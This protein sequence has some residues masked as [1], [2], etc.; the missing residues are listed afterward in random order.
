MK[1]R[2]NNRIMS[3]DYALIKKNKQIN[4]F[5]LYGFFKDLR[6]VEPYLLIYFN[7]L[8]FDLFKI[9]ILLGVRAAFTYIFEVPSAFISNKY[10]MKNELLLCF[11]FYI[12]S[13]TFFFLGKSF[14]V[15]AIAMSLFGLGEAFRSGTHKAMILLYLEKNNWFQHRGYVYGKTRS[16]SLLAAALSALLSVIFVLYVPDLRWVFILTIIPYVFDFILILTYPNYMN[17]P[18]IEQE[19]KPLFKSGLSQLK[20]ITKDKNIIKIIISSATYDGIYK[21]IKDFIQPILGMIILSA[22]VATIASL[23]SEESLKVYLGILY[24][25]FYVL[26]SVAS[27]Q[28]YKLSL[29]LGEKK[30]FEGTYLIMSVLLIVLSFSI[31]KHDVIVIMFLYMLVYLLGNARTPLFLELAA[32]RMKKEERV[33]ILSIK[34]QLKVIFMMIVTPAFGWIAEEYSISMLFLIIGILTFILYFVLKIEN[35]S[36]NKL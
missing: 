14:F 17:E 21:S 20:S 24:A 6:F 27:K 12:A 4:K 13:F 3:E 34:S 11:L 33:T 32:G 9:G 16:Y 23:D 19:N 30:A 35:Y 29:R 8:G 36:K 28:V 25:I 10:G 15:V 18:I 5:C 2:G 1:Y 31:K 26:S 7:F 22:G